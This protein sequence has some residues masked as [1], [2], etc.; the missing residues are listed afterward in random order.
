M[1]II[2]FAASI[3]SIWIKME[4]AALSKMNVKNIMTIQESVMNVTMDISYLSASASR[5]TLFVPTQIFMDSASSVIRIIDF[6]KENAIKTM[7][8]CI[9]SFLCV[10]FPIKMENVFNA[11]KEH[12]WCGNSAKSYILNA[13][14]SIFSVNNARSAIGV[15]CQMDLIVSECGDYEFCIILSNNKIVNFYLIII[16]N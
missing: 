8:T 15:L 4:T 14:I 3:A 10:K 2:V 11:K 13:P 7:E 16:P 6:S 9:K 1:E 5:L 12:I